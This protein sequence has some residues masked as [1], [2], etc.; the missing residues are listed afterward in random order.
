MPFITIVCLAHAYLVGNV[1]K[2][3]VV[4]D[5]DD[6]SVPSNF[7]DNNKNNGTWHPVQEHKPRHR[8]RHNHSHHH[9]GQQNLHHPR[10]S[11]HPHN[12]Q[13]HHHQHQRH[14]NSQS[15]HSDAGSQNDYE[16]GDS[17]S[18]QSQQQQQHVQPNMW[19]ILGQTIKSA[20]DTS[21]YMDQ[22]NSG[23]GM[24][25]DIKFNEQ[26]LLEKMQHLQ[27][28]QQKQLEK[29]A[30]CPKCRNQPELR[31]TEEELTKLRI[32]Y[33]KN[34]ILKKLQLT[35]RPKVSAAH[36]PRPIAEGSMIFPDDDEAQQQNHAFEQF[37]GKTTQ[38]IIFL[39]LGK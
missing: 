10:H 35:E 21:M 17:V 7:F 11:H 33:V 23:S 39:E 3:M 1:V 34:Q 31:M 20:D 2:S 8:I 37:Y 6:G 5:I 28:H 26:Q 14:A 32:E 18:G 36:L 30:N 22:F 19:H 9:S 38:K 25:A 15:H 12:H 24:A 27:Q 16:I 29:T 13:N 4:N